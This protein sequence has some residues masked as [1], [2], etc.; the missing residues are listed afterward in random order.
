MTSNS[1]LTEVTKHSKID[2]I[3]LSANKASEMIQFITKATRLETTSCRRRPAI[4]RISPKTIQRE[5]LCR[6][7]ATAM[8]HPM[9]RQVM[10]YLDPKHLGNF[11]ISLSDYQRWI[12]SRWEGFPCPRGPPPPSPSCPSRHPKGTW[13]DLRR[14]QNSRRAPKEQSKL[15][16]RQ[17]RAWPIKL[18]GT[19]YWQ[20]RISKYLWTF[21]FL[22]QSQDCDEFSPFYFFLFYP[23]SYLDK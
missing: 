18:L 13:F 2:R 15:R 23:K 10:G 5:R 21:H 1:Q 8:N 17:G 7:V 14:H 6:R 3:H 16:Q 11:S 4:W 22:L 9:D 20:L 19:L 12:P